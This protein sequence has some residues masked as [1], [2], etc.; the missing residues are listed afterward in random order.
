VGLTFA[1]P[2]GF[3]RLWGV[4]PVG[5]KK[6][7]YDQYVKLKLNDGEVEELA[8][9]LEKRH[10]DDKMWLEGK[11]HHLRTVLSQRK[12]EENYEKKFTQRTPAAHRE[13]EP[14]ESI[15]RD[16]RIALA[17]LESLKGGL[18]H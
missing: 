10:K 8:V 9:Y 17:A 14:E 5:N 11:V 12:W 15:A 7:A 18:R 1:Y 13:F 4:H 16:P 3:Q 2:A 6:L